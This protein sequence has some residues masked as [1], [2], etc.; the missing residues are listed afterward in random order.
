MS[1]PANNGIFPK[2]YT[3]TIR[4]QSKSDA[5]GRPVFDE[6]EMVEIRIAGD[7]KNVVTRKARDL[8]KERWYAQYEQFKRQEK[9]VSSGTPIQEWTR[10]SKSEAATLKALNIH[11]LEA[12]AEL[13]ESG[14]QNIGMGAR[15]MQKKAIAYIEAANDS[16]A[17]EKQRKLIEQQSEMIDELKA[18]IEELEAKKPGRK[19][20]AAA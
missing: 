8:D 19:K 2:F 16:G 20:R 14:L 17:I 12:L 3:D 1:E 4:N 18:R 6:V 13:P 15:E 10:I 9:Q 7:P 5:E 11:T